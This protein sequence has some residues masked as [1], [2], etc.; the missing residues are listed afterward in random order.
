MKGGKGG[1]VYGMVRYGG[2]VRLIRGD[3][4]VRYR[5]VGMEC[6]R[7]VVSKKGGGKRK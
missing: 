6:G 5:K 3:E 2:V 4:R 7:K 1:F